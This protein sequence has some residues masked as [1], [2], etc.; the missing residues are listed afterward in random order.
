MGQWE[1]LILNQ[2]TDEKHYIKVLT[3]CIS[4]LP[5]VIV[6]YFQFYIITLET[7]M[8]TTIGNFLFDFCA[9][10]NEGATVDLHIIA[11]MHYQA[12]LRIY[13]G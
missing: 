2:N 1:A 10:G 6:V 9:T 8:T 13:N 12:F 3:L 4:A 5:E 11:G 7:L